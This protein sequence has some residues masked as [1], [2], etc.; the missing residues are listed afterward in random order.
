[1]D[2]AVSGCG[3][4]WSEAMEEG[5][6]FQYLGCWKV[7][8]LTAELA[9]LMDI[10][11]GMETKMT[12]DTGKETKWKKNN[13]KHDMPEG[14]R[15]ES[16]SREGGGVKGTEDER[17]RCDRRK[18]EGKKGSVSRCDHTE[19]N[20]RDDDKKKRQERKEQQRKRQGKVSNQGYGK[21]R[22]YNEAVIGGPLRTE[23]VFCERQ[24]GY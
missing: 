19:V 11:K 3:T 17:S 21:R 7:D 15:G 16:D 24:T 2:F 14:D 18:G 9:R 23:R 12:K 10:V 20:N 22:S 1:M 5:F 6:T 4:S 13:R 8:C